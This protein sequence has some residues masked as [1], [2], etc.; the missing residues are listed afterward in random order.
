MVAETRVAAAVTLA[1]DVASR[2][3][4]CGPECGASRDRDDGA[5]GGKTRARSSVATSAP[6]RAGCDRRRRPGAIVAA[7]ISSADV[8]IRLRLTGTR[9]SMCAATR[10]GVGRARGLPRLRR[11]PRVRGPLR[12]RGRRDRR[13]VLRSRGA[14]RSPGRRRRRARPRSSAAGAPHRSGTRER[15]LQATRAR[16]ASVSAMGAAARRRRA[17]VSS[18]SHPSTSSQNHRASDNRRPAPRS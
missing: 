5:R 7:S 14:R 9:R 8:W 4:R 3:E 2:Q 18:A 15:P 11:W 16:G 1:R 13:R 17:T 6:R 12:R 10:V